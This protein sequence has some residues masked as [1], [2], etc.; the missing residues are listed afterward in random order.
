MSK[1]QQVSDKKLLA[2]LRVADPQ[3]VDVLVDVITDYGEGRTSLDA[4]TKQRL[5]MARH[6]PKA[7]RYPLELLQTLTEE[8]QAFGG[9]SAMNLARR[10]LGRSPVPYEE[11]VDDVYKKLNGK[12]PENKPL[13]RKEREIALALFGSQWRDL[14]VE[15]RLERCVNV[16]VLSGTFSLSEALGEESS[17]WFTGLSASKS[18]ALFGAASMSLRLNPLGM[19]ATTG[20]SVHSATAEAYRITVPFVAQMGWIRLRQT[21]PARNKIQPKGDASPLAAAADQDLVLSGEDGSKLMG[22]SLFEQP[23]ATS[24]R[25]LS[26]DQVSSLNSLLSNVPG[27]A[28]L[29][30]LTGSNYVLCSLPIETLTKSSQGDSLRAW[31]TEGGRIKEHAHLFGTDALQNVL[32]S[33]VAWNALSSA[34]GQKHLHDISE[35]LTAIKRQLDEVQ[36]DLESLR[37]NKLVSLI[38]YVQS[39]L[40]H[41]PTDGI[42]TSALHHLESRLV[43]LGELEEYFREKMAAE[44]KKA[45]ELE[46]GRLFNGDTSRSELLASLDRMQGWVQSYLQAVQL[47]VVSYAL[48]HKENPLARYRTQAAKA[49]ASLY[50]LDTVSVESHQVYNAKMAMSGSLLSSTSDQQKHKLAEQL[51]ALSSDLEQGPADTQLLFRT[52]FEPSEQQVLLQLENGVPVGA[53]LLDPVA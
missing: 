24:G 11:I 22:L 51:Q 6:H 40:D 27:L 8:L 15:Q 46:T 48:L 45:K 31:V 3:E 13:E 33:G 20:L 38:D 35:K 7:D 5:V 32:I 37:K 12:S 14:A 52:F 9:N 29:A 2:Q 49:L 43:D 50:E 4:D 44:Q 28:A 53:R 47:R 41:L 1:E 36:G 34:V 18:A 16:K 17:G 19:L 21:E 26:A 10:V 39:L 42:D 23:P 25:P 30:E